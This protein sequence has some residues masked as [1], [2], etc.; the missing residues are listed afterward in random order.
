MKDGKIIELQFKS[1]DFKLWFFYQEIEK[2][3]V[4]KYRKRIYKKKSLCYNK[5]I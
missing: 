5:A 3:N 4:K 2:F 1:K